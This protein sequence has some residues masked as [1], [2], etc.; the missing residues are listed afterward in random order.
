MKDLGSVQD[1]RKK[2]NSKAVA[3]QGSGW[4]WLAFDKGK[5]ELVL[6]ETS[7]Q[8]RLDESKQV[9]LLTVDVWEHAYYLDYFNLRK[10]FLGE[11]WKVVNWD[12]IE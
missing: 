6:V 9:P 8:D 5:K 1:F 3:I 12:K 11:I 4:E 2:F 7:N 10:E